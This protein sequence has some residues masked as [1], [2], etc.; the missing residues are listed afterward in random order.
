MNSLETFL[1]SMAK[2]IQNE[3]P[4]YNGSHSMSYWMNT[5]SIIRKTVWPYEYYMSSDI[6][7]RIALNNAS[8]ILDYG[9]YSASLL[10]GGTASPLYVGSHAFENCNIGSRTIYLSNA[11]YIGESAFYSAKFS[12]TQGVTLNGSISKNAFAY[13]SIGRSIQGSIS[14]IEPNAFYRISIYNSQYRKVNLPECVHVGY[15]AFYSTNI[16]Y[17]SANSALSL[18]GGYAFCN[19][20][21]LLRAT[22]A[23]SINMGAFGYCYS[24][25]T[26]DG[27][28]RIQY[29]GS[30]AFDYNYSMQNMDLPEC[31]YVGS[32]AFRGCYSSTSSYRKNFKM[33]SLPKCS[34]IGNSAFYMDGAL[35]SVYLMGS[36]VTKLG[37][38]SV[39]YSCPASVYVPASLYSDYLSASYW[40]TTYSTKLVSVS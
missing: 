27:L 33:I 16:Q 18:I 6:D 23:S 30:S 35:R 8:V 5:L 2:S 38:S 21:Y 29:I 39:F 28:S 20:Q 3:L 32:L 15:S 9:F 31:I 12:S 19:N 34:Y 7:A 26:Y 37:G 25:S 1:N 40:S 10:Y 36:S 14:I 4:D 17:F 22:M 11:K 24:L 13:A